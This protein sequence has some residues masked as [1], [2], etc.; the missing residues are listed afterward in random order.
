MKHQK[1]RALFKEGLK[2]GKCN[3]NVLKRIV[4]TKSLRNSRNDGIRK[5]QNLKYGTE[6]LGNMWRKNLKINI[7]KSDETWNIKNGHRAE[8]KGI[9]IIL[10]PLCAPSKFD[11]IEI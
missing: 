6:K 9:N 11:A 2:S 4:Q 1:W 7:I 8:T 10:V 3:N 5:V